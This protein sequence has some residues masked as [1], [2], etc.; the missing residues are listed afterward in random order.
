MKTKTPTY[1][2][3]ENQ[4]ILEMLEIG[5]AEHRLGIIVR[6]RTTHFEI[7]Y[8][9]G[10]VISYAKM[11]LNEAAE[12]LHEYPSVLLP[13]HN[14]PHLSLPP[15]STLSSTSLPSTTTIPFLPLPSPH[16]SLEPIVAT[17]FPS[18]N[19]T[20]HNLISSASLLS[21]QILVNPCPLLN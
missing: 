8:M 13:K 9:L 3:E 17:F 16:T 21:Y 12:F 7:T 10:D 14:S 5:D 18:P 6:R 1:T 11:D 4:L 19:P 20:R 2:T 15:P